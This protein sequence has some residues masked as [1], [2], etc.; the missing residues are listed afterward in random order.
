MDENQIRNVRES[1]DRLSDEYARRIYGELARK[2]FDREQLDRFAR[3]THGGLVCD[4]GCG[5]GHVARY[6]HDAGAKAM[7]LDLSPRMIEIARE[8]N[9]AIQFEAGDMFALPFA[10]ESLAG[11]A[12][13]YA[14]VNIPEP[15]LPA[16]FREMYRVL[17][18]G[19]MLLVAFHIGGESLFVD[20]LWG[21]RVTMSFHFFETQSIERL[22]T[23]A[24][25]TLEQSLERDPYDPEVEHQS[26]RSYIFARKSA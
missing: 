10:D 12:A 22:V 20:E 7:G 6:L 8:L 9:P 16:V 19:G 11:I 13:F 14:I 18:K 21:Q 24:G 2:R 26:R 1:Y 3:E 25:F 23:A 17:G 15:S 4:V 5:P